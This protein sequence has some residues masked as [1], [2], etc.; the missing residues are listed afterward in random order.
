MENICIVCKEPAKVFCS[1]DTSRL[2]CYKDF[3]NSHESTIGLHKKIDI[4]SKRQELNQKFISTIQ[5]LHKTKTKVISRSNKLI[6]II[7][8]VAKSKLSSI[9]KYIDCCNNSL[10]Y[11]DL[12]AEKFFND[13]KNIETWESDLESFIQIVTKSF[14]FYNNDNEILDPEVQKLL[15]R[16]KIRS[17][18]FSENLEEIKNQIQ[19]NFGLYLEGHSSLVLSV[20]V[21]SDNK[22]IVSGSADKTIRI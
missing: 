5:N 10:K 13:Y 21:T 15:I 19:T 4:A 1:C 2:Y 18:K 3:L 14:S 11:K 20:A 16:G 17:L 9:E 8:L 7:Q 22:Y 6:N 12:N